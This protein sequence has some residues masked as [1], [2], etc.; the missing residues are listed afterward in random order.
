MFLQ[1]ALGDWDLDGLYTTPIYEGEEV[2]KSEVYFGEAYHMI[3]LIISVV[4]I[5]NFV[6]AIISDA[7]SQYV[8]FRDGLY[9]NE[10]LNAFPALEWDDHFGYL[11]CGFPPFNLLTPFVMPY[12]IYKEK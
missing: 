4:L 12:I 7:Y 3:F 8:K 9:V 5:L 1:S 2:E 10:L 11:L 6:I